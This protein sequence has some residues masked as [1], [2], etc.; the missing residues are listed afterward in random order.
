[1][2]YMDTTIGRKW[3][4]F[5]MESNKTVGFIGGKF[6]PF[7]QGHVYAII[8]A[9]NQ[10]DKLHVILSSS[11]N[12]DK[13]ICD[14]DGMKYIPADIRLSWLGESLHNLDNIEITH[15]EDDQWDNNYNW[16]EGANM[17]KK[18]IGQ[19]I[20]CVFSSETSYNEHFS[21]YYPDSEHIVIDDPRKTVTISATEMRKNLYDNWDKLPLCVRS[22][23]TKKVVIIGTESSGKSTLTKKL[24]K[25]Y[26]T[27][28]VHEIGRDYCEKYS[29]QL[30][31]D[32]FDLIA[33]EHFLLQKKKAGESNKVMF[34][35]SEA[36][37]TQYYLDMYFDGK[38]S[39]LI[40]EII[41]LQDYD[42]A[43]FLEP[44]IKWVEDGLRFAGEE[45]TRKKNNKKLKNMFHDRGIPFVSI[46][47]DYDARFN[48]S[49]KLVDILIK[50]GNKNES[51]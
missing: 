38:K 15:I 35:D 32:M 1:M 20:D 14:R 24:A 29:N 51:V 12:R 31:K 4:N 18:A 8:A 21:K 34:I 30:T 45:K 26:N 44:D 10:V 49:R 48:E 25:F 9:S 7:H 43:I 46:S 19:K 27:N 11:K 47:G 41:K 42:L 40:E 13:E 23:F 36:V 50:G 17:I 37:I 3:K 2:Q 39:P 22:Y 6:L 33:M 16:E 28:Y 5:K